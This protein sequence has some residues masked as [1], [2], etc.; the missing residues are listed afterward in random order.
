MKMTRMRAALVA[1]ALVTVGTA[2]AAHHGTIVSYDREKQ[3]TATDT[4]T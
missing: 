2:A 3:W 1:A 4:V